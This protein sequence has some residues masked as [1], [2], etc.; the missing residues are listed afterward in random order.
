MQMQFILIFCWEFKL[1]FSVIFVKMENR[2]RFIMQ[3]VENLMD[4][5]RTNAIWI[6]LVKSSRYV[7]L[8]LLSLMQWSWA[9]KFVRWCNHLTALDFYWLVEILKDYVAISHWYQFQIMQNSCV[10]HFRCHSKNFKWQNV[11]STLIY[12]LNCMFQK[13]QND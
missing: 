6:L 11:E 13:V 8:L 4:E 12:S 2:K 7:F 5:I 3:W 1:K 9:V 10:Q